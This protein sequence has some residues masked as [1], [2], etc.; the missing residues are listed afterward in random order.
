M[1]S[2]DLGRG[3][4]VTRVFNAPPQVVFQAWTDPQY[5]DWFFNDTMP[6]D[7]PISVDLRVGGEWRQQMVINEATEYFT[8]GIYREIVPNEKLVFSFGAIGGWPAL[9]PNNLDDGPLV[10]LLFTPQGEQTEMVLHLQLPDHLTEEATREWLDSGMSA[11]W[12]MTVDRLVARYE[13]QA[14]RAS[15]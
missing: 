1:A 14:R 13:P 4:T 9:D 7:K 6:H 2:Y 5:L 11:G 3:F 15:A 8:G 10:T 12:G